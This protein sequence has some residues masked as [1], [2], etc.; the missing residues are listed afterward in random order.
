MEILLRSHSG[1]RWL[2]LAA[3][4]G[5]IVKSAMSLSS[6]KA[7]DSLDNK[8]SL[9]ALI[10]SH[11]QL[12][13]GLVL[14]MGRGWVSIILDDPSTAMKESGIRF[15]AVE[16][17]FGMVVAIALITIGRIA[18][19]KAA[20]DQAKFKKVLFYFSIGL[21]IILA[22]IPWP[23]LPSGAGRGWF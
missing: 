3:I 8:L 20:T 13:L 22:T 19:K 18:S 14:Y 7:Y 11:L 5:A 12:V 23:F 15:W 1:L 6:G 17:I 2:V 4:V 10:F 16:H 21:L 9:F